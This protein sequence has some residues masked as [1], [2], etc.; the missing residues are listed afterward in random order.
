MKKLYYGSF[1][2]KKREEL[3]NECIGFI[4]NDLKVVYILPSRE[5]MFQV[6]RLFAE[7]LGGISNCW[8]MGFDNLERLILA[9][10]LDQSGIMSELEKSVIIKD[11]LGRLPIDDTVF[12]KVK[13]K[14]A[15]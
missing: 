2:N 14:P 7:R 13:D 1:A 11:V 6:R 15:L 5:A 3:V 8:V 12:E 10:S 4:K 9:G